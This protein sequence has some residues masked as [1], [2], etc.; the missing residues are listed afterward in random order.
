MH[1][2]YCQPAADLIVKKLNNFNIVIDPYPLCKGH[3]MIISKEHYGCIGEMPALL[4]EECH[5]ISGVLSLF[6][7]T[8]YNDVV[9]FEHGRAGICMERGVPC[10]HMHLHFLPAK[11][12][13]S[14]TLSQRF[15]A[16]KIENLKDIPKHFHSFGEYI[17]YHG[18]ST[19][20]SCLYLLNSQPIP[21]HFMRTVITDA[22]GEQHLSDWENYQNP[23]LVRKNLEFKLS[24]RR[25]LEVDLPGQR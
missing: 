1:C 21:P 15:L 20:T 23:D 14:C 22:R 7:M 18:Q 10:S 5:E 17:Y 13:V 6:L 3:V 24:L 19:K 8:H 9:S 4:I 16:V 12:D 2:V 25:Y 11:V